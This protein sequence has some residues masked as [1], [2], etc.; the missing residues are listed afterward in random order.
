MKEVRFNISP[1]HAETIAVHLL[2]VLKNFVTGKKAGNI[3]DKTMQLLGHLDSIYQKLSAL[4]G[5]QDDEA[6][7]PVSFSIPEAEAFI[8]VFAEERFQAA[9]LRDEF[10]QRHSYPAYFAQIYSKYAERVSE[11]Y[12]EA[13]AA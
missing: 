12:V 7:Q 9:A 6:P 4:S 2:I 11:G 1:L 10:Y 3:P 13:L 8:R 5:S